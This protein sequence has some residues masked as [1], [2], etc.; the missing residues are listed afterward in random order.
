MY[1]MMKWHSSGSDGPESNMV[2]FS[3]DC[4]NELLEFISNSAP[5]NAFRLAGRI[6][7]ASEKLNLLPERGRII[8]EFNDR[9]LREIFVSR[10]RI[11]YEIKSKEIV[12]IAVVHMSRDLQNVFPSE[13]DA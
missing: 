7:E 9:S 11:M 2:P 13:E 5:L 10:Y 3:A 1:L 6:R 8:P 4:L 12:V